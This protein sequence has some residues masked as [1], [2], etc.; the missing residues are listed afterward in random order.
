MGKFY[1]L[2]EQIRSLDRV[3]IFS[4][5]TALHSAKKAWYCTQDDRQT[6]FSLFSSLA[7]QKFKQIDVDSICYDYILY[8]QINLSGLDKIIKIDVK[9][10]V[11]SL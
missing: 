2:I 9:V 1:R 4:L 5:R 10:H 11:C 7:H 3:E 6:I 8:A